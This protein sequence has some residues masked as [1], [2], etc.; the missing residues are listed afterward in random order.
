M[1]NLKFALAGLACIM[2][3]SA[4]AFSEIFNIPAGDLAAA[5]SVYIKQ[6]G[7]ALIVSGDEVRGSRTGGVKGDY[8]QE[9]ALTKLLNGTGFVEHRHATGAIGIVRANSAERIARPAVEVATEPVPS[10]SGAALET[11]TVTSSKIGGDVQNIPIAITAMSQEQLTV[12]Q[13]AG[14]PDLVKQV[15]NLTFTKTN[16]TGYSI[17]IRGIGTQAISVSTDP[18]VAVAFNDT[19]FLR[20]HFFEQEFYDMSQVEILRGP[21]DT[22][23]GRNATAG[24]VNLVSAKP[25]DQFE[26]MASTD[27]GNYQERRLEGMIN[28][29]ITDDRLDL[30][31][32]GEWT[33]RQG[34]TFDETTGKRVDGRDLW[35]ARMTLGMK[36]FEH[37]QAYLVWEHF[38]EDD[39]RER[40]SKQLCNFDP[41]PSSVGPLNQSFTTQLVGSVSFTKGEFVPTD[42]SARSALSQ[43]CLPA[44]LYSPASYETPNGGA[45]PIIYAAQVGGGGLLGGPLITG[46]DPYASDRQSMDLRVIQ[47]ELKPV[48]KAK[49]DTIELNATYAITPALTLT[50][51]TGFNHDFLGSEEDFNRFNSNPGLFFT[52]A[53]EPNPNGYGDGSTGVKYTPGGVFCDPQL[54][55]STKLVGEDLSQEHAWQLSQ[56]LRLSSNFSG[57]FNFS[58]GGD[59]L[60]YETLED[61]YVFLNVLSLEAR[62]QDQ[63]HA[64]GQYFAN[65]LCKGLP[66][67]QVYPTSMSGLP[68][69]N[70]PYVDGTPLAPGFDGQGHNYF[71]SENPYL[72]DSYA[73]FAEANY[74]VLDALKLTAGVRW[75]DDRKHFVEIPSEVIIAAWG[76]PSTGVVNQE[77][78]EWT[79]RAVINWAPKLDFT[80]Q[81]LFYASYSHGYKAGGA[82][83]PPPN[84]YS[85][86]G[87]AGTVTHPLTF[88]PEFVD[89]YE[90]GTKNALLNGALTFNGDVFY[91]DYKNYQI[92]QVVDRTSVNLNFN[93]NVRGAE[94]ET[95]YEPLPGLRFNFA[96]GWED[97]SLAKGAEAIDLMDRTAGHADWI[98]V[99]PSAFSASNCIL[100]TYVVAELLAAGEADV[101]GSGGTRFFGESEYINSISFAACQTAYLIPKI[102][103]T[104]YLNLYEIIPPAGFD[105]S[106][107]PNNGEGFDKNLAG[108][109][110]PNAPPF[111]ASFGAQYTMP[112]MADWAGTLRGDYYWQDY[113]W[114]RVFNDNPYDRLRGYTNINLTLIFTNQSGWQVMAY[115]KNIFNTTAITGA[116]LNS[117]DTALTTNVFVTEPKLIGVRVTKNW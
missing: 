22:L 1:R 18:A 56:E 40:S 2:C 36:P 8:S 65:G 105:P 81:T 107:A 110:L 5:L 71:R 100:P 74:Q 9:T 3:A 79:G 51:E 70:C 99:K 87:G 48:Y 20:N 7:V 29:P 88:A 93:A 30:R 44:S 92:S 113:S 61:Y 75:T 42:R 50:S 15:P 23:Y 106:T 28:L 17:Q 108:N 55:C 82:N 46:T 41:G 45:I 58:A 117:D 97:S 11:V 72:L 37:L 47:S 101:G 116:F 24:V 76:Y 63:P 114:A 34:Y 6:T 38:S 90:A 95:T 73:G 10:V 66:A 112:L 64:P 111:T 115:A 85:F 13:T 33:K 57:P 54:G 32:A 78:K 89:A 25:T 109:Q 68:I 27:V 102:D 4:P 84:F 91:Y 43:G 69:I 35:S 52:S 62:F 103:P 39:D 31:V 16:F 67:P 94:I 80:D 19:P 60:H 86:W 83:P 14:G 98:V 59:Y 104:T 77:W 12:T 53:D 49:N 96:G 26:A 21:Q